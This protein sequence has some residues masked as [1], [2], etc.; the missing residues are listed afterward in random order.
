V[1][2]S[3]EP[4]SAH[5]MSSRGGVGSTSRACVL[6]AS[7]GVLG[8]DPACG[9]F[10]RGVVC[11]TIRSCA[12][13]AQPILGASP[14]PLPPQ[15]GGA[16]SPGSALVSFSSSGVGAARRHVPPPSSISG[17]C[18]GGIR[19]CCNGMVRDPG[20]VQRGS[21]VRAQR[22]ASAATPPCGTATR[23]RTSGGHLRGVFNF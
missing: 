21:R 6:A 20:P 5:R 14:D 12:L 7:C 16:C 22:P 1:S 19:G 2:I 18:G 4:R 15:R 23:E 13:A 17:R 10:W 3:V 11:L 9:W 8:M